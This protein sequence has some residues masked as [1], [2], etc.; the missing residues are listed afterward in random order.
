QCRW[1]TLGAWNSGAFQLLSSALSYWLRGGGILGGRANDSNRYL[2]RSFLKVE[3][4]NQRIVEAKL[5]PLNA[6]IYNLQSKP[7][8]FNGSSKSGFPGAFDVWIGSV[9]RMK[10]QAILTL[11]FWMLQ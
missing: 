11:E 9:I 10:H 7:V 1:P 4:T 6:I 8:P 5:D 3:P 2:H